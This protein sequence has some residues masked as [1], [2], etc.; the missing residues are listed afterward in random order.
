MRSVTMLDYPVWARAATFGDLARVYP[1]K[2]GGIE[3]Y[4]VAHCRVLHSGDLTQCA[5][6]KETPDDRG[7]GQAAMKLTPKFKVA[8]QLADTQHSAPLWVDI[9]IRLP[10]PSQLAD[11]TIEAP[12]WVNRIDRDRPPKVFPPEAVAN[13][14]TSGK[15]IARCVV[16]SDGSMT[17][18]TPEGAEPAGMGFSEAAAKLASTLKMNL[19]SADGAPV[20]GGVVHVPVR[21]NLKGG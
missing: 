9:P 19:W 12:H 16:A 10:P 14:V 20:E 3:G 15:G 8:P 4:A 21:L 18:C 2:G 17:E 5:V 11:R 1:A 7:F 13:G 6:I